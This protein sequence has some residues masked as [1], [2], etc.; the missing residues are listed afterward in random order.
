VITRAQR[1]WVVGLLVLL[2][3]PGVV[4]FDVWPLT[5]W[6]LF[7]L[8]RDA[9]QNEWALDAGTP[10]GVQRVDLE[11]LPLAFRNAAWPL[12]HA[13]HASDARKREICDA[14]LSGVQDAMPRATGLTVTRLHRH[15]DDRGHVT[16]VDEAW[17]HCGAL[18][19][20]L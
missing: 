10:D 19:F 6:R 11:Q 3:V 7:S 9:D 17:A 5:G 12:D 8:S 1:A 15:M 14:L 4:G 2:L 13:L 18:E 16:D 20:E